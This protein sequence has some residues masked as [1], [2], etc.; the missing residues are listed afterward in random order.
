MYHVIKLTEWLKYPLLYSE[1]AWEI[2]GYSEFEKG[3]PKY[4]EL[5]LI[6]T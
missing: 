4:I 3:I 6:I 5:K 1:E 2:V